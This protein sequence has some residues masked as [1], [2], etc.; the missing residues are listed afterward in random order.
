MAAHVTSTILFPRGFAQNEND[1]EDKLA[2]EVMGDL[3]EHKIR[4]SDYELS[5]MFG[6][7]AGLVNPVAY[8][9][10]EQVEAF[11]KI[12]KKLDNGKIS[13]E[14]AVD[15]VLSGF[16]LGNI[17]AD[18][19]MIANIYQ[20]YHQKQRFII[21]KRYIDID[22]A[23]AIYG[24]HPN[25]KYVQPGIKTIFNGG[26]SMFY[27]LKDEENPTLVEESISYYRRDD[28]ELPY[29]NGIYMGESDIEANRIK[30]RDANDHPR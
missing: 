11:Q 7:I 30:H 3:I 2:G 16:Q 8:L 9:Q 19:I 27:D 14:D 5:Y 18:E 24:D 29:V 15:E 23:N 12:R 17:P 22:E 21:R 1:E 10:P 26:D 13:I 28:M 4:N 25:W 20:F 6:I